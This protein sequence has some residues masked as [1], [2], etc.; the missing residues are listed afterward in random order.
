MP[1][2]PLQL[3]GHAARCVGCLLGVMCGD[4]LGAPVESIG[5]NEKHN[6][7]KIRWVQ[8]GVA[9]QPG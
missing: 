2:H 5:R 3:T 9:M 4:V 1:T 8:T 7:Q 6:W